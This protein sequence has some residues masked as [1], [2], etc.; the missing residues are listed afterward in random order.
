MQGNRP[1]G[2]RLP[3]G[4]NCWPGG[5]ADACGVASR[6]LFF[7]GMATLGEKNM[8]KYLKIK[9]ETEKNKGG[10]DYFSIWISTSDGWGTGTYSRYFK[11][12]EDEILDVVRR[13]TGYCVLP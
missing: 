3:G 4:A 5:Q 1:A 10:E 9:I 6:G 8:K 13:V 2:V 12:I 11:D 7:R